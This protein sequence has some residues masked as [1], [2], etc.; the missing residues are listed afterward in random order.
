[1]P[2]NK[3]KLAVVQ[4]CKHWQYIR[5]RHRCPRVS[6]SCKFCCYSVDSDALFCELLNE[7]LE[8]TCSDKNCSFCYQRH[9]K[10]LFK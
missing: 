1:M 8:S 10:P 9:L 2:S 7:W 3:R 5:H 6:R 4:K